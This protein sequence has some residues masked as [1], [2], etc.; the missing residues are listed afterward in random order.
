M[1][2]AVSGTS[3]ISHPQHNITTASPRR[4]VVICETLQCSVSAVVCIGKK[5]IGSRYE[6]EHLGR[7]FTLFVSTHSQRGGAE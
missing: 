3:S 6:S 7:G 5:N 2:H 1:P 4:Y